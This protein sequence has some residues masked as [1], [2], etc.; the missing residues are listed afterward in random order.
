ML[1]LLALEPLC[2]LVRTFTLQDSLTVLNSVNSE[3]IEGRVYYKTASETW[4]CTTL[5]ALGSDGR[6]C[7]TWLNEFQTLW[8]MC[9]PPGNRGWAEGTLCQL[10]VDSLLTEM[11]SRGVAPVKRALDSLHTTQ[12]V[13]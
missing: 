1:A 10:V 2:D 7:S 12:T 9:G 3:C 6:S 13:K 4:V 5:I 11:A 8:Y